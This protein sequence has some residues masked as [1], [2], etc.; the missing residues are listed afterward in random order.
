MLELD[1]AEPILV[2]TQTLKTAIESACM[3]LRIDEIASGMSNKSGGQPAQSQQSMEGL[4]E[5]TFGDQRDG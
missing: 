4:D 5:D 2:K 1:I 3:L